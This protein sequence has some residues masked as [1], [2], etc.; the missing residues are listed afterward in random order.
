MIADAVIAT[1]YYSIPVTL[2]ILV[3][4][5]RDLPFSRI[6]WLFGLFI[7][8]C[9]TGHLL[10]IWTIWWPN[11]WAE[12][13]V[14]AVTATVSVITALGLWKSLPIALALPSR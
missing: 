12:G 11:Y 14:K 6:F 4:K 9:G 13:V 10:R 5:R 8:G 7:L 3:W 1:A 2:G